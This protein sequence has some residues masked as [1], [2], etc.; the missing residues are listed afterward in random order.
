MATITQSDGSCLTDH[1]H[2]AGALW[3]SFKERLGTSEFTAIQ[4]NLASLFQHMQLSPMEDLD[5][6]FSMEEIIA[7]LKDMPRDHAPGP[8]GFNG[9]FIKK[10]WNIIK[11]DFVRLCKDFES[12]D[13]DISSINGSLITLIPKNDSPQSVNDY[14]PISLLKYSVK[15]LTKLLAN[16]L[17][18]VILSVIHENQYGF[19]K[20]R[21]IQDCLAWAYQF[22]H[23]CHK[24]K[25]EI[26]ILTLDFEKAF[27]KVEHEVILQVLA[28]KGFPTKW[29][30]WMRC[31]LT[32]G[33][34]SVLLN[35]IP[36]KSFQCKR[37]V[38]Q[39][40]PLSPFLFVMAADLLQSVVNDA[41]NNNI[42][43]HPLGPDF[44]GP[45]PIIQYAD[46]TLLIMPAD[47]AELIA[48]KDILSVFCFIHRFKGKLQQV[49][50]CAN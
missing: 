19:I 21:T 26:V 12:G 40:D 2:K 3:A 33:S 50:Y 24:P 29:V 49:F 46:D 35:G 8:D 4:Y 5:S 39:G 27:D 7:V 38:R 44:G 45:Y 6:P 31:I 13:L 41:A 36:G 37:D 9:M 20:G 25:K 15:F 18:R 32:S 48:L 14:R 11:D 42:I 34:S 30:D 47:A 23:I 10:C 43:A 16:R 28:H 1:E 17:Q 22:L